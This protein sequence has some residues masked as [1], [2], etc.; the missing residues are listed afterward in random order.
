MDALIDFKAEEK[1]LREKIRKRKRKSSNKKGKLS[2]K[3]VGLGLGMNP[4]IKEV[5]SSEDSDN[6]SDEPNS[7]KDENRLTPQKTNSRTSNDR[8]DKKSD[9]QGLRNKKMQE[10]KQMWKS[11]HIMS[12]MLFLLLKEVNYEKLQQYGS[13]VNILYVALSTDISQKFRYKEKAKVYPHD[14]I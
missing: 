4:E 12:N 14:C 8:S 9:K 5:E 2:R 3:G 10:L 13:L 1:I 11:A 7:N 6:E